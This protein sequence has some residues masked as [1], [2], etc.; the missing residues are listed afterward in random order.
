[1]RTNIELDDEMVR[2]AMAL[3]G[4]KTKKELVARALQEFVKV[5]KIRNIIELDGKIEFDDSY[6]YKSLRNRQ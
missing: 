3:S 5:R 2:E 4:I 1:M 6:D